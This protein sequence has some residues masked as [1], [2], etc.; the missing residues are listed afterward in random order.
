MES[1]H[2]QYEPKNDPPQ[3]Y[4]GDIL[5]RTG[6]LEKLLKDLYP[7]AH[8]NPEKYPYFVILTQS[9]DL[10]ADEAR[11]RKAEHI[12]LAAARPIRIFLKHEVSKIQT[13]VLKEI[14]ICLTKDKRQ[15]LEKVERLLSNEEY[16]FFYLHPSEQTPFTEALVAYLRVTF[17][18]RSDMHYAACLDAKRVQLKPEFRAKLGW[19]TTLVFGRVAT[20]DFEPSKRHEYATDY[21]EGIDGIEWR[22]AKALANMARQRGLPENIAKLS[23]KQLGDLLAC[24]D[25]KS[26]TQVIAELIAKHADEVWPEDRERLKRFRSRLL[27]DRD[28]MES[29]GD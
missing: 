23:A 24:V 26:H 5:E 28:L 9:C 13:P 21:I 22:R 20:I 11:H 27:E 3:L 1:H 25:E 18:L 14:G 15:L 17:P 29:F 16:P 7:Y 6:E 12:T 8:Q 4:Q 10:V 19:L 2:F